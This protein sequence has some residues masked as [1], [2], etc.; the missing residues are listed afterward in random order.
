MLGACCHRSLKEEQED[1]K[2]NFKKDQGFTRVDCVEDPDFV[3][4]CAYLTLLECQNLAKDQIGLT[5]IMSFSPGMKCSDVNCGGGSG[6]FSPHKLW[7]HGKRMGQ[8]SEE[9]KCTEGDKGD[10][11]C[12]HLTQR[13]E[14]RDLTLRERS[15]YQRAIR[16][17]YSSPAVW[18][19]FALLRAEYS[20]QAGDP[21][22]FLPWHRYFLQLV[23]QNLQSVSSCKVSL[24][25]FEWTV[26]TGSMLSSAA[27]QAGM[28]GGDGDPGSGCI[29]H[30]PFQDWASRIH[31]SPCLRR[32]FNSSVWLPDAVTMQ[33]TINQA[34]FQLFSQSLQTF[35]GLFRL[36]V[37]GHMAS[38]LAAYDP[39]YL[40][41]MAFMD[42]LWMQWQ[43]K[44]QHISETYT[45]RDKYDQRNNVFPSRQRYM[46]MKPFDVAPDDVMSSQLQ[47]C[48]LY[49]P[50]TIGAPC[51]M[52]S[53]QTHSQGSQSIEKYPKYHTH[54]FVKHKLHHNRFIGNSFDSSGFNQ[55]GFDRDGYDKSGWD[56]WGYGKDGFNRDLIDRDGYDIYGFNRY[57]FNRSSMT[58]YGMSWAE[59]LHEPKR[60]KHDGDEE[61]NEKTVRDKIMRELFSIKG[62]SVYGFNP[63][64]LDRAGFDAFGFRRDGY[65]KDGCN[66]FFNGPHYLRFYFHTQQQLMSSSDQALKRIS[67][68]CPTITSLPKHWTVQDWMMFD[69]EESNAP[70]RQ[71]EQES[72]VENKPGSLNSA[73][74]LN[75]SRIWLPVT[76]DHRFCFKL[77]WFSGCP[78]GF[79]PITCPDLCHRARCHGYPKAFC[80][81][82][83]CGS[84]FTEWR[85]PITG[86]HII[87]NDW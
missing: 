35:S 53:L 72:I 76:P 80:H 15:L 13:K 71:P 87:C 30:H 62:Y 56:K 50:I 14:I 29:L 60:K 85:D 28:F 73:D 26:D 38:P 67:R 17:L 20:P 83:N 3:Y 19:V 74:A 66:W 2:G 21:V 42:K 75:R 78:L 46:K 64:G 49:V 61:K 27:W 6:C 31:W 5:Q 63:F 39:L 65:D 10:C 47:M 12:P 45:S 25:Y 4:T 11:V 70:H 7:K 36:W 84:C 34:D 18:K 32:G 41:H 77:H 43:E 23:E 55:L 59:L 37:G 79:P 51:N 54:T 33:Q 40:S 48:V 9:P 82:H 86:N 22:F 8:S 68:T 57:G 69:P 16:K 1:H 44:H 52:T 81:M 58:W 24:P